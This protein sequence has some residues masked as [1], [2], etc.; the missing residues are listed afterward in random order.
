MQIKTSEFFMN[1]KKI[2]PPNSREFNDL[3]EWEIEKCLGG[4]SINGVHISNWLYFH[5]NHWHIRVDARDRYGNDT[6]IKSLPYL[7][8]NEW[9]RAEA[10]ESCRK[11]PDGM[12]GYMEVG[13]R[14]GGK[15]EFEASMTGWSSL[16]F[17]NTQNVI[18]GGNGPDLQLLTDKLDF[19]LKNM[20]EG[21]GIGKIDKDWRKPQ[22]R[23]GVKDT[24]NENDVWSYIMIRNAQEGNN[25]EA[26][27]GTTAKSFIM[28]EVGKY[29]FS[30]VYEAAK[31]SFLSEN[32]WRCIPIL[33]GTGGSFDNGADAERI[34]YHPEA[35][36]FLPFEQENGQKTCLF[37]P[38]TYRGDCKYD[39]N[40][41]DYLE[42]IKGVKLKN[43]SEL[44]KIPM[45]VS[46]KEKAKERI[47]ADRAKKAKD[48][49][50]VEYLKTIM[51]YPLTP[52]ECFLSASHNMFNVDAAKRQKERLSQLNMT[53]TPIEI[54]HD[55][56]RLS[57][58][59]TDK[60]PIST[61]PVKRNEDIEG[62][63]VMYEPPIQGAP[64]GLYVAGVDP[65][66]QDVAKY[67]DSLGAIYIYKRTHNIAEEKYQD[68]FVAQYVGRPSSIAKWN[69]TVRNLIKYYNAY[70]LSE[71]EDY[72]FIQDMINK[73]DAMYLMPQPSWLTDISPNMSSKRQY[74]IPATP[75]IINHLN[76]VLKLYTEEVVNK[77]YLPDGTLDREILGFSKILDPLLLDEMINFNPDSNYDRVRA[78]SIAIEVARRL[79]EEKIKVSTTETDPRLK[80]Y[81]A[82]KPSRSVLGRCKQ[83]LKPSRKRK[84]FY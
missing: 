18:V 65:Y 61:F 26:P 46:D 41:A 74:G 45:K 35:N 4:V 77:T 9:E 54:Y 48:P 80:S 56:E 37:M 66:K 32:G 78:A 16:M 44:E 12:K 64:F 28:D 51:Y 50:Q 68:M 19:G 40:L 43:R 72:G 49:N 59:F 20:W 55:G 83:S 39:S 36:N 27:A 63:V 11:H 8:D 42:K 34:F 2:P 24:A 17:E 53:G 71:S 33:V 75:R 84:S 5:I 52:Q 82:K 31:P 13:L 6:R 1:M 73:G 57:H 21:I 62:V 25:T 14:Q 3:V 38:G 15:S 47:L 23:L 29:L 69:E 79:D 76:G 10:L 22:V 60:K 81:F 58:R 7:R 30:E 70:T 67:S